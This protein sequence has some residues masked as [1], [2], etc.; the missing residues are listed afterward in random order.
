MHLRDEISGRARALSSHGTPS[1]SNSPSSSISS[2]SP[3]I[4]HPLF[5]PT[6]MPNPEMVPSVLVIVPIL[7]NSI[8]RVLS[9]FSPTFFLRPLERILRDAHVSDHASG[10]EN[11]SPLGRT[12]SHGIVDTSLGGRRLIMLRLQGQ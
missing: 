8:V 9:L 10:I 11:N 12:I 6:L 5:P 4:M 1:I 3:S 2:K 7:S